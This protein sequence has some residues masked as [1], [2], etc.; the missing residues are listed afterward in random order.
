MRAEQQSPRKHQPEGSERH[1]PGL[2]ID[3]GCRQHLYAR[4]TLR[5]AAAGAR[6][7]ASARAHLQLVPG[8]TAALLIVQ[9]GNARSDED[10]GE[11]VQ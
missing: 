3:T 1:G 10:P 4:G 7:A 11:C 9:D 5:G 8:H 6:G 2:A